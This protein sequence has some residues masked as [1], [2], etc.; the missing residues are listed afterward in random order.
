MSW[1]FGQ[2]TLADKH[3]IYIFGGA[4]LSFKSNQENQDNSDEK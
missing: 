3:N 1:K 2:A 4:S